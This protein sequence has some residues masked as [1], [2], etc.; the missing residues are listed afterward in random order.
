MPSTE[1]S[2]RPRLTVARSRASGRG[3]SQ[4]TRLRITVHER[5]QGPAIHGVQ[6]RVTGRDPRARVAG[7]TDAAGRFVC[8][9]PVKPDS[10]PT[11]EVEVT[12]PRDLGGMVERK[13]ITLNPDR[14]E[15]ALPFFHQVASR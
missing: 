9:L 14:T 11:Y 4:T 7:T 8:E 13:A 2:A 1:E 15:F 12:W 5:P 3:A 6:V 10:G